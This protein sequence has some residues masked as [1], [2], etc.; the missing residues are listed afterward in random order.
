ML[1]VLYTNFN[2]RSPC[3]ERHAL[4][5]DWII[6]KVFQPTLPV[7]GATRP[8]GSACAPSI[9]STHAPRAGSD[10]S[11]ASSASPAANFNPRSPCGERPDQLDSAFNGPDISTHAPRAGSDCFLAVRFALLPLF[12]PTL[13]V[14]GATFASDRLSVFYRHFNPRSPCGERPFSS[15]SCL[16]EI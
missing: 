7:R 13:P 1:T 16:A 5:L 15:S 11:A 2:P 4:N 14:R 10:A 8:V 12:Q 9:I 3:G 6:R